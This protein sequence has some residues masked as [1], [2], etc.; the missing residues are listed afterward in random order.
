MPP[1]NT[2]NLAFNLIDL[3]G[4]SAFPEIKSSGSPKHTHLRTSLISLNFSPIREEDS[5]LLHTISVAYSSRTR[6]HTATAAVAT[7]SFAVAVFTGRTK[8][9]SFLSS[10]KL[11]LALHTSASTR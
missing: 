2:S 3:A 4:R 7:S 11:G 6:S 9:S 1:V 5:T 8:H 10:T